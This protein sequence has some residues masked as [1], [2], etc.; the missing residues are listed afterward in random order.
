MSYKTYI[1][2]ALVCGSICNNTS[3]KNYLL[4]SKEAGML[5][6]S[7]RSIREERSKQRCAMQEFS[8]I[9][10]SLIKGKSGWRVGSTEALGNAFLQVEHR[11]QRALINF[12]VTQLRRYVHGEIPLA[13]VYEDVCEILTNSELFLEKSA[14]VQ[15]VFLVRLLSELGYVAPEPV[16][17]P[18][19][20]APT[21]QTALLFYTPD[22][23]TQVE[24]A[25]TEGT[26][27]SHL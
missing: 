3:D 14:S 26:Q 27:A 19:V 4:F 5:W 15:K 1:T 24:K 22:M 8:H 18:I 17:S 23:V 9:R 6:C 25:I 16:W 12:V 11:T 13:Q 20:T 2:E 10:V 21:I 7:A